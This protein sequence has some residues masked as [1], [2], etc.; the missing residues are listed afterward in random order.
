MIP[1]SARNID[2][3]GSRDQDG[4]GDGVMISELEE[5]VRRIEHHLH[6]DP[7]GD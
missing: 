7:A 4:R 5:R 1:V 3:V 2:F 6:L